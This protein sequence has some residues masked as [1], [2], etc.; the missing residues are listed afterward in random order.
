[1]S[2]SEKDP[3]IQ[4]VIT[5]I[6][7]QRE[8]KM[9]EIMEV[10]MH[11]AASPEQPDLLPEQVRGKDNVVWCEKCH[12]ELLAGGEE[13]AL[14]TF[15]VPWKT[16]LAWFNT[17]RDPDTREKI[18]AGRLGEVEWPSLGFMQDPVPDSSEDGPKT[19]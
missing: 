18:L 9:F 19:T 5:K 4:A 17:Y 2:T 11:I 10:C 14:L 6:M 1:M 3:Q 7:G 13:P 12:E 8:P 16:W 15:D